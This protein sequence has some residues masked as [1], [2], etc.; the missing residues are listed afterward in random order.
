M[1]IGL[2]GYAQSGKDTVA[3]F[4]V[5]HYGYKR[6]AFAD[7][8]RDLLFKMNPIVKPGL[9]LQDAIEEMGWEKA[10]VRI[11][12]VR[13]IMQELGVGAREVFGENHWVVEAYKDM[14]LNANYVVTDVRFANE[15]SWVKAFDGDIW[16]VTR[17]GVGP[18]NG[19]VS[20][21]E[22]ESI[23]YDALI[24]ND[25]DLKDLFSEVAEAIVVNG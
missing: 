1:I 2:T 18:V 12:E 8:I 22:L 11:P 13:R 20:E 10:K 24:T 7:K 4:L 6:V 9:R 21:S 5:E 15:A 14:D 25:G 16:R 3:S 23:P 19:H 17:A